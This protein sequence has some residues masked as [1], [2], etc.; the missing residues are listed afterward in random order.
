MNIIVKLIDGKLNAIID[1]TKQVELKRVNLSH[2]LSKR[3]YIDGIGHE[4][5]SFEFIPEQI[6]NMVKSF[7]VG[8][9][10]ETKAAV[11]DWFEYP[12]SFPNGYSWL[13]ERLEIRPKESNSLRLKYFAGQDYESEIK[14]VRKAFR[15]C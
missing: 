1:G 11:A 7:C 10:T 14:L 3:C 9:R 15:N 2:V 8:C 5:V 12:K 6:E 4:D 13:L